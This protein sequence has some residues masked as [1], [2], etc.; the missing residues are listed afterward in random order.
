V[1]SGSFCHPSG[2]RGVARVLAMRFALLALLAG[3][4]GRV[5]DRAQFIRAGSSLP[6][7]GLGERLLTGRGL[8]ISS[9]AGFPAALLLESISSHGQAFS[10]ANLTRASSIL[11]SWSRISLPRL[12][13]WRRCG[14]D[15]A[16]RN[17]GPS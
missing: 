14:V 13:W 12:A 8:E 4:V 15:V 3:A 17:S 9:P 16:V 1:F 5:R 11:V 10:R 6:G 7:M 2:C